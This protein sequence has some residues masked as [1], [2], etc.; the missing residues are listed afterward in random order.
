MPS[1]TSNSSDRAPRG[2][3]LQTWLVGLV[4][5][6]LMIGGAE[7]FWR[8]R[9]HQPSIVDSRDLWAYQRGRV[10]AADRLNVVLLGSS[11]MHNGFS[12]V[13]LRD[14]FPGA[15]VVQL[16]ISGTQCVATLRD[17]ADDRRFIGTAI[18]EVTAPWLSRR[19]W[20]DQQPYVDH[21]HRGR[22]ITS[23][24]E[25]VCGHVFQSRLTVL[26]P[27][28]SLKA[29]VESLCN[30]S[31]LP[32]PTFSI[33]HADRSVHVD[34]WSAIR[35]DDTD[36]KR[37]ERLEYHRQELIKDRPTPDE[38]LEDLKVVER[39][40]DKIQARGGRVVFVH[41]PVSGRHREV[42]EELYPR[43]DYWDRFVAMTSAVTI[44]FADTP[45]LAQF[46]CPEEN[47]LDVRD[48]AAFTRGLVD[49]L[50]GRG[51]FG[52]DNTMLAAK[53]L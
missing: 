31:R 8:A 6:A 52:R 19:F 36:E 18:C 33:G 43:R 30:E 5:A 3:W 27:E 21:F 1:S 20:D 2:P 25:L 39:A 7:W 40:V 11:R 17:L 50:E 42:E 28:L 44:H 26:H 13:V 47:H 34:Y 37:A 46:R 38:W 35:R 24:V 14:Q 49:E 41:F 51:V 10:Y 15:N 9:G 22:S 32:R 29:V 16:A 48:V 53:R 4:L 23:D 45:R 12:P